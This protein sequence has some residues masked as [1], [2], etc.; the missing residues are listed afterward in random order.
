VYA[1]NLVHGAEWKLGAAIGAGVTLTDN[2][3]LAPSSSAQSDLIFNVT[4]SLTANLDGARLKVRASFAPTFYKYVET[5]QN[6]YVANNL[7]AFA[8]LEAAE[9]F[10][11]IEATAQILQTY[12]SPFATQPTNGTSVT[13]NRT[14]TTLL[15]LSPYIKSTTSSGISYLIR[16]DNNLTHNNAVYGGNAALGV[17][18]SYS[19]TFLANVDGPTDRALQWG[20]NYTYSYVDFE[21][22]NPFKSQIARGKLTHPFSVELSGYVDAGYE[23]N[24]YTFSSY[25]GPVYGAGFTWQPTPRT[26]LNGFIEHR[27]FGPSYGLN[28]NHRTRATAWT[29]QASRNSTNYPQQLLSLPVGPT[30]RVLDAVLQARIPDPVQRQ[31]AV[32]NFIQQNGLPASLGSPMTFYT[33]QIYVLENVTATIAIIGARNQVTLTLFWSNSVPV[34]ASGQFLP[35]DPSL[36][37]NALKQTGATLGFSHQLSAQTSLYANANLVYSTAPQSS[38]S[39]VNSPWTRQYTTQLGLSHQFSPKT[40]GTLGVRFVR[41]NSTVFSSYTEEA[42]LAGILHTF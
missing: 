36:F 12:V 18:N 42:V 37:I 13:N 19:N 28:F 5:S 38:V 40:S 31:Q 32:N 7:N 24:D 20:A 34:S 33:N 23:T 17:P 35:P 10:F 41:Y 25:Q 27:F 9:K 11:Y 21:N 1:P 30:A 4:P 16:D 22:Q 39:S 15:G 3:N 26:N 8:L 6:D 14:Q 2:V 29:L